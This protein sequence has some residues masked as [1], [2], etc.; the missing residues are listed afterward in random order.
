[1]T[2][3]HPLDKYPGVICPQCRQVYYRV[4]DK[5]N[6]DKF[7]TGEMLVLL[8]EYKDAGWPTFTPDAMVQRLT[9]PQCR[10]MLSTYEGKVEL[11]FDAPAPPPKEEDISDLENA[12]PVYLPEPDPTPEKVEVSEAVKEPTPAAPP[13]PR[14]RARNFHRGK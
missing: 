8:P 12:I 4:N 13:E 14:K 10:H 1:M 2:D 5:F 11:T 3:L 7:C 6:P 9:C